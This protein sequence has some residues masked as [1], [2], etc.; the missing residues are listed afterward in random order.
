MGWSGSIRAHTYVAWAW[1]CAYEMAAS[2]HA[3]LHDAAYDKYD[4]MDLRELT[5]SQ[6]IHLE[7]NRSRR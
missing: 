1:S 6:R 3:R 7:Y 4:V 2:A 5:E